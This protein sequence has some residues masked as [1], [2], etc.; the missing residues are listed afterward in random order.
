MKKTSENSKPEPMI[1]EGRLA[2]T[3]YHQINFTGSDYLPS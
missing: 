2:T 3:E 1:T